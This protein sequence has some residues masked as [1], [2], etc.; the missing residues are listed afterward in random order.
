MILV[1]WDNLFPAATA[2]A[3]AAIFNFFFLSSLPTLF[4]LLWSAVTGIGHVTWS[5]QFFFV[6]LCLVVTNFLSILLPPPPPFLEF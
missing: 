6:S 1:T 5:L 3:V 4:F 2:D